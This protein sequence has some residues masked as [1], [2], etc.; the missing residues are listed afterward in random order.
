MNLSTVNDFDISIRVLDLLCK[1]LELYR[2]SSR[3]GY[4]CYIAQ[5]SSV[6][7]EH[8]AWACLVLD[9][10]LVVCKGLR[11]SNGKFQGRRS[12]SQCTK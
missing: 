10:S 11:S 9:S 8:R 2:F 3:K 5:E 6:R 7:A 12:G 4:R 1:S